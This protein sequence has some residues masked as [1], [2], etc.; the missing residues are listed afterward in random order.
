[1]SDEHGSDG[2]ARIFNFPRIGFNVPPAGSTGQGAPAGPVIPPPPAAAPSNGTGGAR[3]RRSPLQTLDALHSPALARPPVVATGSPEGGLPDTF[4]GPH[5]P[6]PAGPRMGALSMAAVLAIAVAALRGACI[7]LEDWR[8]RRLEKAEESK[9][10]REARAKHRLAMAQAGHASQEA[11]AKSGAA[12][13]QAAAKHAQTLRGIRDKSAAQR[14]KQNSRVPSSAE[15]GQK[16][17]GGRGAQGAGGKGPGSSGAKS[18]GVKQKDTVR[19]PKP[20]QDRG[21]GS[22]SG[23]DP[24]GVKKPDTGVRKN[25]AV[26]KTPQ[27]P[28]KKPRT[29]MPDAPGKQKPKSPVQPSQGAGPGLKKHLPGKDD[30]R[31]RLPKAMKDHAQRAAEKRLRERRKNPDKPVAWKHDPAKGPKTKNGS[32]DASK[33]RPGSNGPTTVK[34]PKP[35]PTAKPPGTPKNTT[36]ARRTKLWD[37]LKKDTQTAAT[38]RW[39]KRGGGRGAPPLWKTEKQRRKKQEQQP[40]ASTTPKS[41]NPKP[42]PHGNS[43]KRQPETPGGGGTHNGSRVKDWWTKTRDRA[44]RE[45]GGCSGWM[46]DDDFGPPMAD[47]QPPAP[48]PDGAGSAGPSSGSH[49]Q[50]RSPYQNAG[51]AS[52][53]TGHW[54]EGRADKPDPKRSPAA[55]IDQGIPGLPAA[56]EPHTQRPGTSRPRPVHPMPPA[57]A[58][59]SRTSGKE[60]PRMTVPHPRAMGGQQMAAEHETEITLDESLDQLGELTNDGFTTHEQSSRMAQRARALRGA[61]KQLAAYLATKH[62][63]TGPKFSAAMAF[64]AESMDVLATSAEDL[65]RSALYAAEACETADNELNDAYRPYTQEA[66]DRGLAAPSAPIHNQT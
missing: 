23:K 66:A 17:A 47:E 36:G 54:C 7:V 29:K 44:R 65:N 51:Q 20:T 12:G 50:R 41:K 35:D 6:E 34:T 40:K 14:A 53:Q 37:A 49:S 13:D 61:F 57:A 64:L 5:A 48:G 55:A 3:V 32:K 52:Q 46:R 43:Q 56:P 15:F 2:D 59:D 22:G 28:D 18:P 33:Q 30:G 31:T 60:R 21:R 19:G 27:A 9:P 38:D 25:D 11:A 4:R 39:A 24:G 16:A 58:P 45:A 1:M 63:L 10:L 42:G 8:Q 62:N 26:G